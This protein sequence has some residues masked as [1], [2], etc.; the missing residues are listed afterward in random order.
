[1]NKLA[2]PADLQRELRSILASSLEKL[3]RAWDHT[4]QSEDRIGGLV[5]R[6]LRIEGDLTYV[7]MRSRD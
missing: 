3:D 5:D 1:M 7:H 4:P 6:L 2:S